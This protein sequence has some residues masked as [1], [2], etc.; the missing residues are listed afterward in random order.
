MESKFAKVMVRVLAALFALLGGINVLTGTLLFS[1]PFLLQGS[2]GLDLTGASIDAS[3]FGFRLLSYPWPAHPT[4]LQ[5][6]GIPALAMLRLW[7]LGLALVLG[8]TVLW[9][10]AGGTPFTL[11]VVRRRRAAAA[12]RR[13]AV[14]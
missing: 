3:L 6:W 4:P 13:N 12:G 11:S 10:V 5:V 14:R 2:P 9:S 7:G 8:A 1:T